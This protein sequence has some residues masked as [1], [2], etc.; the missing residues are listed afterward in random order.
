VTNSLYKIDN[1]GYTIVPGLR[2]EWYISPL[3]Q[4]Y[5]IN[6]NTQTTSWDKP[7]PG[8][9]AGSLM[10][11]C[12]IKGHSRCIWSLAYLKASCNVM[13]ASDDGS[14]CQWKRDGEPV[15]KPL[16]S[17]GRVI[18]TMAVSPDETMVVCGTVDGRLRL[19]NIKE[20]SMISD[21]W[22]G[23]TAA[24]KC[25]DWSPNTLEIASGSE[26]GTIR[27]WNPN[28][29]RQIALPIRTSHIWLVFTIKYSPQGDKF[30]SGGNGAICVWSRDGKLVIK[31]KGHDDM[32]TS[33]CWPKDGAHILR[34][35][36]Q[37]YPKMVVD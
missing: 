6:H 26:D 5:F 8:H 10:P 15:G 7:K 37:H 36:Q 13:S 18:C 31:I 12:I 32:V 3:G 30:I 19:W 14:I 33:L 17:D 1:P 28:T 23:H 9:P 16:D 29:G 25:P 22:E 34:V 24:V 35:K 20:G 11:E 21:P 4:S 27:R 2:C